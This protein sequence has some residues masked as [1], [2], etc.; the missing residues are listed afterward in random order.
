MDYQTFI[1]STAAIAPW[2][3]VLISEGF[4]FHDK[5]LAKALPI[6]RS[7]GL[8]ME[9]AMYE[10]T[11]G[12]NTQK[13]IIFLMGLSL[14]AC[15]KLL[16]RNNHFDSDEFRETVGA[17]CKDITQNELVAGAEFTKSHGENMF[18][19]YGFAGARGEAEG[20]FPMVFDH[21]L[22]QLLKSEHLT[23]ETMINALLAI[24]ANNTDTNILHRGGP[25]VL[26]HF[27]HL[28]MKSL[29]D[30]ND[31]NYHDLM[32]YCLQQNISPGG[33]ADL[34]AVTIF[35]WSVLKAF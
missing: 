33:S 23:H 28:S 26:N 6:I 5:D 27:K 30:F 17:I 11:G 13:G 9:S 15:G 1:R 22:P 12:I 7:I 25:E 19:K 16:G 32:T 35:V 21:G 8:R 20:G 24:A 34:L 4:L 3:E 10:A 2:F 14:F 31:Q 18:K 29:L